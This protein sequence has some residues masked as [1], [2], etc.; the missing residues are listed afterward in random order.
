MVDAQER[1]NLGR[2]F[3]HSC[4]PNM[5]VQMVFVDTHDIRLPVIA[6]FTSCDVQAGTEL[7]WNYGYVAGSVP[8]KEIECSCG[9][10]ICV[11]RIL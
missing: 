9:S 3:N 8:G 5:E 1:G 2:F 10:A 11:G 7:C 4:D 6:F